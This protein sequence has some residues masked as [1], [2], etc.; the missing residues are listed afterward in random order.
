MAGYF[1]RQSGVSWA[2]QLALGGL[3][4]CAGA[5]AGESRDA[6][7]PSETF[8]PTDPGLTEEASEA[9]PT[10]GADRDDL[11]EDD[12]LAEPGRDG[13]QAVDLAPIGEPERG[14]EPEAP[15]PDPGP[16]PDVSDR[17]FSIDGTCFRGCTSEATDVDATGAVDGFGFENNASC[18]V[19]NR[20][21]ALSAT[22]CDP[23]V[24][25][26]PVNTDPNGDFI[27]DPRGV[28]PPVDQITCPLGL[29]RAE[30]GC[31]IIPGLGAR[32]AEVLNAAVA[33]GAVPLDFL[34][35]GSFESET[36]N[37]DYP[38][39]DVFPDGRAK[40]GGAANFGIT[41][42]NWTMIRQ[43][44][45]AYRG[46]NDGAYL[47]GAEINDDL[48]LEATIYRECR[49]FFG[50]RWLAGHRNGIAGLNNPNAADVQRFVGVYEWLGDVY[51][52]GHLTDDTR[53]YTNVPAI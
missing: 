29:P 32:K 21:P 40:T 24:V 27:R 3:V 41:K 49:D 43:C 10:E 52:D 28:C 50:N 53:W 22:P 36:Y 33:A 34:A 5:D 42:M 14:A 1:S 4:A 23:N 17:G 35:S 16:A 26:P 39:G 25:P 38:F 20:A 19:G 9:A 48:V 46:L 6:T 31:F 18:V 12:G 51:G 8:A 11:A 37:T 7:T 2:A 44:H 13:V 45:P 30:C 15:A 47:R